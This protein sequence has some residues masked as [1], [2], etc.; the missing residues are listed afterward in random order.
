ML[1]T[2]Q[3]ISSRLH[4]QTY[5]LLTQQSSYGP[6]SNDADGRGSKYASLESLHNVVHVWVGGAGGH[7]SVIP[8]ASF[9]PIF[10]LHHA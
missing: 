6:F 7:M 3:L 5:Q 4:T 2:S 1:R 9:D 8:Y 10:W